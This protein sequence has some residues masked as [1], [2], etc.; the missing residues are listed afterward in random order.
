VSSRHATRRPIRADTTK[1]PENMSRAA[2]SV[3][4]SVVRR[5]RRWQQWSPRL[6]AYKHL[7]GARI[8]RMLDEMGGRPDVALELGVGPGGIA[9]VLSQSGIRIIGLDL[10]PE[11][12]SRAKEHCRSNN[13][14]LMRA[15]GFALPL[16]NACLPLIYASQVLHLFES[17]DRLAILS[18]VY[19][20][21][22][23]RGRFVFDMKNAWSHPLRY[24]RSNHRAR[25][26]HF[27]RHG[28]IRA[29]LEHTGFTEISTRPGVLPLLNWAE[30]PDN[31]LSRALAHTTFFIAR[32]PASSMS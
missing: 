6:Y 31:A 4:A 27:P 20:V 26:K 5:Y 12:L 11:A 16:R 21:L 29:L 32:K 18:E 17:A 25:R 7:K 30:V 1:E 15:S 9:A 3:E 10:S 8:A 28:E 13:V 2:E 24:F 22:E 19:R 14:A 23:A